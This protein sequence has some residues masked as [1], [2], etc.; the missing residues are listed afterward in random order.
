[1]TEEERLADERD[2]ALVSFDIQLP[3]VHHGFS[4]RFRHED[5]WRMKLD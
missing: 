1:M 2:K 3:H 4:M 5:V